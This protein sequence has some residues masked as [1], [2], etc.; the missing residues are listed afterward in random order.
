MWRPKDFTAVTLVKLT[1]WSWLVVWMLAT[2]GFSL[3]LAIRFHQ[4]GPSLHWLWG[5][6]SAIMGGWIVPIW[7]VF[8]TILLVWAVARF[9][10]RRFG[11]KEKNGRAL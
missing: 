8:T 5:S 3:L 6:S 7:I 2:L 4:L 11:G 10:V 1:L 9:T